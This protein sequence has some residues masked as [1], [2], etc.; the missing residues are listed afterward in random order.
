MKYLQGDLQLPQALD[1]SLV[2]HILVRQE[3]G[4]HKAQQQGQLKPPASPS[5]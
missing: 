5:G 1:S 3:P 4:Q 2:T